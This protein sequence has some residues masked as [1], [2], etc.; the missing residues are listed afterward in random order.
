[1]E[2][3]YISAD[4]HANTRFFP[5][6]TWLD[7]IAPKFRDRAPHVVETPEGS[8]W[9]CDGKRVAEAADGS[10]NASAVKDF[11]KRGMTLPPGA[12]PTANP[13]MLLEHMDMGSIYARVFYG[14]TRRWNVA[15][16]ELWVEVNRVQNDYLLELSSHAPER[17]LALPNL[18]TRVPEA[19][20]PELQRVA[21]LGAKAAEFSVF[22]AAEPVYSPVWEPL[23]AVA[24]D[25]D[26]AICCHIGDKYGTPYPPN[27]QGQSRAHFSTVPFSAGPAIT[28][29]VFGGVLERHPT[30]R[31][32]FAECRVGWLP[33]LISWMDR[34]VHERPPDPT[35]HLSLLPSEYFKRQ[36]RVTFEDDL[37]GVHLLREP[38]SYL[39][40]SA[41]WGSDY[42]HGQGLWPDPTATIEELFAGFDPVLKRA[43]LFDRA[44]DFFRIKTPVRQAAG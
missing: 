25:T 11:G 34:Q 13:Q 20:V 26:L 19:C 33:F 39:Q 12:L 2:Y 29:F 9:M 30:L 16:V 10:G 24:V 18:P 32:C 35:V 6:N 17:I 37:I 36:M 1:V 42:P 14:D 5:K 31:V 4:D 22:D 3:R 15:D 8:V 7:R 21:K 28:Q 27:L 23:W 44:A 41:M 43:V 38:W 40:D